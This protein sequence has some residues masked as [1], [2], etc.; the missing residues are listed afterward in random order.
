M[1]VN[2]IYSYLED[3]AA[4]DLQCAKVDDTTRKDSSSQCETGVRST[5]SQ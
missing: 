5:L 3:V 4:A 2:G 1:N